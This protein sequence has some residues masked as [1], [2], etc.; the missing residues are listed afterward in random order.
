MVWSELELISGGPSHGYSLLERVNRD[1]LAS[2]R[3]AVES[4]L[5]FIGRSETSEGHGD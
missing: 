5:G 2:G 4:L 1:R 3:H